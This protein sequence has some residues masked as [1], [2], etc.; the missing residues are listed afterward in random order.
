MGLVLLVQSY[1]LV[2]LLHAQQKLEQR[3]AHL[4]RRKRPKPGARKAPPTPIT[5]GK[6][7][8]ERGR[9]R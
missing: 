1:L 4:Y 8:E 6:N 5:K 3:V 9:R 7:Y 2:H